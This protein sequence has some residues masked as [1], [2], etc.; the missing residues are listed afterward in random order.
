MKF[1]VKAERIRG[2][3]CREN[4]LAVWILAP[5]PVGREVKRD[6]GHKGRGCG[7]EFRLHQRALILVRLT[8]EK[9]RSV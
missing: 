3:A 7:L 6:A 4:M 2:K 8:F 5:G 9:N 1:P